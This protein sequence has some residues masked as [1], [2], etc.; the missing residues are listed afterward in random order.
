M[1][2]GAS[3]REQV[4]NRSNIYYGWI[5]TA[6][7]FIAVLAV[8]SINFSF[9]VFF[10]YILTDLGRSRADTSLVFSLQTMSLYLSAAVLG[11]VVDRYGTRPLLLGGAGLLGAGMLA[12][13]QAT[14]LI[15]LYLSYGV[16]AGLGMGIVYVIGYTTVPR[17]FD[18]RRGVA[19]AIG[20]SGTGIATLA[21]PPLAAHLITSVGWQSTYFLFTAGLL[22]LLVLAAL[23]IADDP[24]VLGLDVSRE[25]HGQPPVEQSGTSGWRDQIHEIHA[26]LRS[27]SFVLLFFGWLLV[28]APFY[29]LVG[30]LV[31]YTTDSS[32][33]QWGG[34]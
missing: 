22:G 18:R 2:D 29:S 19:T 12:T 25:F 32:L 16:I 13:T 34:E 17:W 21:A 5:V 20:S 30:Y 14:S 4:E 27:G 15:H 26:I 28:Y 6:A 1:G 23:F 8:F 9:G 11:S 7:C 10:D 3:L 31:T 33:A 24:T